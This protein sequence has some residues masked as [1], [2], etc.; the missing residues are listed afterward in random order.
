MSGFT[1]FPEDLPDPDDAQVVAD[2]WF[3]PVAHARVRALCQLGGAITNDQLTSAME[4][5]MLTAFRQLA[6][7][8]TARVL[9][10]SADLATV[11]DLTLNGRNRAELLWERAIAYLASADLA[12]GNRDISATDS[13]LTRAA[14]KDNTAD[15]DR[16]EAYAA[17]NDLLSI[18]ADEPV[19]RNRVSML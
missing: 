13:G 18:G 4:G 1:S 8:R 6:E 3:P 11:T 7:W 9:A 16:R 5:G 17:I 19:Q 14:E 12:A 2:G 15:E 10:G